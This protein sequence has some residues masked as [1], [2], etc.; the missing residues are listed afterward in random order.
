MRTGWRGRALTPAQGWWHTK[1]ADAV[2]AAAYALIR[3][4]E[5]KHTRIPGCVVKPGLLV[6]EAGCELYYFAD[7]ER[8]DFGLL[9][10]DIGALRLADRLLLVHGSIAVPGREG[11][12]IG[13]ELGHW[14]LHARGASQPGQLGLAFDSPNSAEA[15]PSVF[16]RTEEGHFVDGRREPVYWT[17]EADYFAASLQMPT[18]RY[19]PVAE[20]RLQEAARELGRRARP[21]GE[22]LAEVHKHVHSIRD[23][24]LSAFEVERMAPGLF[25]TAVVEHA[26][27]LLEQDHKGQ[28]SKA[29]QRR[30]FI[31]LGLAVDVADRLREET[32]RDLLA[33]CEFVLLSEGAPGGWGDCAA[34]ARQV[35]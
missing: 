26:L 8:V 35:Q 19:R 11:Q 33:P 5:G 18:D 31:E 16:R 15:P 24:D 1:R 20:A 9:P 28:V 14:R 13:H 17:M 23:S 4:Y 7:D 3:H 22:R 32:G 21:V 29:A 12:T 27:S 30:R 25:D 2:E 6:E 34:G 10:E